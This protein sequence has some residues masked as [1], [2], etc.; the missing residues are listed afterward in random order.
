MSKA[1][2]VEHPT[3]GESVTLRQL[4]LSAGFSPVTVSRRYK[5]GKRGADLIAPLPP[6]SKTLSKNNLARRRAAEKGQNL[7]AYTRQLIA[8]PRLADLGRIKEQLA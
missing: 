3:T 8:A 6:Q 2:Y 5:D 7:R 1:I 4:A